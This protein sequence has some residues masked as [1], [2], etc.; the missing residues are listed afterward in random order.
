MKQKLLFVYFKIIICFYQ[1]KI[2]SLLH[3]F[4]GNKNLLEYV[5]DEICLATK[6]N[7]NSKWA[8]ILVQNLKM[9]NNENLKT[10]LKFFNTTMCFHHVYAKHN[11]NFIQNLLNN[12]LKYKESL[13]VFDLLSIR[14]QNKLIFITVLK[15][16]NKLWLNCL[17][18]FPFII[19]LNNNIYQLKS[20]ATEL[21]PQISKK[22]QITIFTFNNHSFF[23]L[24]INPVINGCQQVNT[25]L[26]PHTLKDFKMFNNK[27]CNLH[28]TQLRVSVNDQPPFCQL[29][30]RVNG[31]VQFGDKYSVDSDTL[32][33][34]QKQYNFTTTLI[35]A[36]QNF[37]IKYNDTTGEYEGAVGQVYSKVNRFKYTKL[38]K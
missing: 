10:N 8:V 18:C 11:I 14:L 23:T 27:M 16:L 25:V 19:I 13:L 3:T 26:I 28:Q 29:V 4:I 38:Q 22:F 37:G 17:K 12:K 9:L 2:T 32:Y 36:N 15:K 35:N 34:L 5:N 20:W 21:L 7:V 33:L 24:F 1:I 6:L 31:S 30:Q